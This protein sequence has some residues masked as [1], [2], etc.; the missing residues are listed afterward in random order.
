MNPITIAL[1][2]V[3]GLL[4]A[5]L[6]VARRDRSPRPL[7]LVAVVIA[8]LT[9]DVWWPELD[10]AWG[11]TILVLTVVLFVIGMLN[12]GSGDLWHYSALLVALFG[13]ALAWLI[14]AIWSQTITITI[15]WVGIIVLVLLVA[16]AVAT[17]LRRRARAGRAAN[18]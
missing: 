4:A 14:V 10:S 12:R 3:L 6:W 8:A 15:S 17:F 11:W 16:L 1:L 5:A 7:G 18:S 13:K 9:Y 2:Y